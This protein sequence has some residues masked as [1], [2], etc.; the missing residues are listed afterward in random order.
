M[1]SQIVQV[2]SLISAIPSSFAQLATDSIIIVKAIDFIARFGGI[3][4]DVLMCLFAGAKEITDDSSA[5]GEG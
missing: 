3:T 2:W 4:G 5:C 1:G